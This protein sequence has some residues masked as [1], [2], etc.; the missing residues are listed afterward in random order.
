MKFSEI[1]NRLTGISCPVFG[2]SWNPAETQRAVARRII[3]FLEGKRLL[4]ADFGDEAVCHCAESALEI[5]NFLTNELPN[6]D[7]NSEL[8]SYIRAMR[9]ATNKFLNRFPKE[10]S[11]RCV[12][13]RSGSI[14]NWIFITAVGELRGIFGIMI[15]QISKAYGIDV[16]DEL[17]VI[18][19]E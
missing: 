18:I 17:A 5:K 16:E 15:G 10:K 11:E 19:P 12:M 3:I 8:T 6:V 14:E 13:C 7:E 4:S 1:L 2:L 9:T